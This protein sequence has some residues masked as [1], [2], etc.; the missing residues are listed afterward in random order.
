[1]FLY[2]LVKNE[3]LIVNV[4]PALMIVCSA[5]TGVFISCI[6]TLLHDPSPPPLFLVLPFLIFFQN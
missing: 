4:P 3:F 5:A 6:L 1:V 2:Q